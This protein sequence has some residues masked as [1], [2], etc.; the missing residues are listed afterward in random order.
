[1]TQNNK[2]TALELVKECGFVLR[3]KEP[4]WV[5]TELVGDEEGA[6]DL[7]NAA[8][9]PLEEEL[10]AIA[11]AMHYPRCWDDGAYPTCKDAIHEWF[12]CSEC[13]SVGKHE[14]S[15]Q[16]IGQAFAKSAQVLIDA[17]QQLMR[18]V[19]EHKNGGAFWRSAYFELEQQLLAT[20]EAYQ[21]VV[22]AGEQ[23]CQ[24]LEHPTAHV[25]AID[26]WKLR[27]ALAN[28]PSLEMVE[29]KKLGD[30]IAVLEKAASTCKPYDEHF[31]HMIADRKAKLEKMK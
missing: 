16:Q 18:E 15:T 3:D 19:T 4:K 9:K 5:G 7:Y 10:A 17:K 22:E 24:K 2:D 28:P 25:T 31:R 6:V 23:V 20:Q 26:M 8:R 21:R 13:N 12:H 29:R 11:K 30:E 27:E 1:M 14:I